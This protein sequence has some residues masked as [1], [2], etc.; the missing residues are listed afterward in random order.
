[1][2]KPNAIATALPVEQLASH[3]SGHASC[4]GA[5]R[6]HEAELALARA[7]G[8]GDADALSHFESQVTP[9]ARR[10]IR[11]VLSDPA[12][13]DEVLQRLRVSLF[14]PEG[15]RRPRIESYA[16]TGPLGAWVRA[17]AVRLA[18]DSVRS[19]PRSATGQSEDLLAR[20]DLELELLQA[21]H[22][23][24]FRAAFSAAARSLPR[25]GRSMLRLSI[26]HGL[27]GSQIGRIFHLSDSRVSETLAAARQHLLDE[28]RFHLAH[29][30][31][32]THSRAGS[33]IG[34]LWSR[35]ELSVRRLLL[36]EGSKD[37]A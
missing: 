29:R 16:G 14:L 37:H 30:L 11:S 34:A 9:A 13:V 20:C 27:T 31:G 35:I 18:L 19:H 36:S 32:L 22:G 8:I 25:R 4:G 33:L 7:C 2:S 5:E 28:T 24:D 6:S 12:L 26:V 3:W 1:M 10:A 23:E 15:D 17:V 21:R